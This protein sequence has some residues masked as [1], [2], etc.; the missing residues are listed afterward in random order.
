M[1]IRS[2]RRRE[3]VPL[4]ARVAS[5]LF[6]LGFVVV[7]YMFLGLVGHFSNSLLNAF[8]SVLLRIMIVAFAAL[9]VLELLGVNLLRPLRH[10]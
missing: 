10:R 8:L 4:T 3:P 9:G 5:A 7:F 2:S 6:C 1:L